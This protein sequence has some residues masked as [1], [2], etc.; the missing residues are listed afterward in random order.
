MIEPVV[1]IVVL[2]WNRMA[3]TIETVLSV[4]E[5][6][7]V[8]PRIWLIDQGSAETSLEAFRHVARHPSVFLLEL[9][10]NVG[11][12]SGRNIGMALGA[13]DYIVSIDNDAVFE[14]KNAL[15]SV[16][17]EFSKDGKLGAISFRVKNYFTGE[18]D[19]GSWVYPRSL[20]DC[21]D[22]SFLA[23]RYIGAGHAIRRS[24]LKTTSGY[25]EKLFYYWEELDLSYQLIEQGY[26]IRYVPAISILHK[27]SPEARIGWR[28]DRFYYLVR[29]A[30]YLDYKYFRS[31]GR[32]VML[33]GGYLLKA[34][35]NRLALQALRAT[36]DALRMMAELPRRH[37]HCLSQMSKEYIV[38]ND[39]RYRGNLWNRF[40]SEV[41]ER[42]PA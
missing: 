29:N 5:Q 25:D 19:R 23:T 42:L 9:A 15:Q 38:E 11:V 22:R 18:D 39:V 37:A 40:R 12:A 8:I 1:D 32:V 4:V 14:G 33:T 35:Y 20:M 31:H 13:S 36:I 24:A 3:S 2:A 26:R 7:G 27:V 41:L 16:V 28:E 10:T 34:T 21:R 30:L 17:S 6:E